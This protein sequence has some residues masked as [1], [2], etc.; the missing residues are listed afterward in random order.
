MVHLNAL[1]H[2]LVLKVNHGH[3]MPAII[4]MVVRPVLKRALKVPRML[5]QF[6]QNVQDMARSCPVRPGPAM[7]LYTRICTVILAGASIIVLASL[8]L[9]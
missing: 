5:C 3:W 1:S 7:R 4:I 9:F 6:G 8:L 2:T